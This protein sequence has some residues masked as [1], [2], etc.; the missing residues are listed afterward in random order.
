VNSE[1]KPVEFYPPE[2]HDWSPPKAL[3]FT[4]AT[5]LIKQL[6]DLYKST[7]FVGALFSRTLRNLLCSKRRRLKLQHAFSVLYLGNAT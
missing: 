2:L 6:H 7:F 3:S 5:S 4:D 1:R